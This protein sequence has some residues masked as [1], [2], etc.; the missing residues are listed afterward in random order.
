MAE[1]SDAAG[2]LLVLNKDGIG[3]R[4]ASSVIQY[5]VRGFVEVKQLEFMVVLNLCMVVCLSSSH[6][7]S[8]PNAHVPPPSRVSTHKSAAFPC[9]VGASKWLLLAAR[10]TNLSRDFDEWKRDG[11]FG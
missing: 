4:S 8:G 3:G 1:T 7:H 10:V 6:D 11:G 9:I 5:V 2:G